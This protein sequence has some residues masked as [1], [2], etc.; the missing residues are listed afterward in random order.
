MA[1]GSDRVDRIG[2]LGVNAARAIGAGT[3]GIGDFWRFHL[4]VCE[5]CGHTS[6]FTLNGPAMAA[7][8]AASDPSA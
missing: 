2:P 8:L 3:V 6:I 7:M 1:C 5:S 4:L